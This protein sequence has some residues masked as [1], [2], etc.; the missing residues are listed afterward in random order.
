M[1]PEYFDSHSLELADPLAYDR[2]IRQF[3]TNSERD[4]EVRRKGCSGVLE[5]D[6]WRSEA[7][8]EALNKPDHGAEWR[9][10]RDEQGQIVTEEKDDVPISKAEGAQRWKKEMELRFLRGD[11]E[12]FDYGEVDGNEAYDDHRTREREEE[13]SWFDEEEP[14]WAVKG[15]FA[16]DGKTRDYSLHLVGQTGVQDF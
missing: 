3:Q 12:D 15:K 1:H 16:D 11:D 14:Q 13:E 5:A 6:L 10:R 2:L 7:K 9:Y 4:A 8:I